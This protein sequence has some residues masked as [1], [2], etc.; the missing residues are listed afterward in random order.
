MSNF[1][2][3]PETQRI[4]QEKLQRKLYLR[5]E[6]LK[7]KSDP[8]RH[9]SGAGGTVFDSALLR[10][11]SLS[12]NYS[13]FF[14]P[15]GKNIFQGIVYLIMPMVGCYYMIYNSRRKK[16]EAYRKGEVAYKDRIKTIC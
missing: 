6:F 11:Q 14:R 9:A 12:V 3:S 1:D 2:V 8:F 7:Q 10:Y 15:N 5:N 4:T 16:E 13:Q